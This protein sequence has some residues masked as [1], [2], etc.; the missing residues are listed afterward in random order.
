M[1]WIAIPRKKRNWHPGQMLHIMNRGA[2]RQ[3]IFRDV[4][5]YR[6]FLKILKETK[7]LYP[8]IFHAYCLMTNH[9]HLMLQTMDDNISLIMKRIGERYTQY[10][11]AKYKKDGALFRGR[12]HSCEITSENYFLQTSRY[13]ALNPVKAGIVEFPEQYRWSSYSSIIDLYEQSIVDFEKT[14]EYFSN[15]P[16]LYRDFVEERILNEPYEAEIAKA[17]GDI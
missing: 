8:C 5:D 4:K 15:N 6:Y 17:I 2:N 16:Q 9:Y 14:L 13:I 12:Y 7:E 1:E 11:N 10:F 3:V